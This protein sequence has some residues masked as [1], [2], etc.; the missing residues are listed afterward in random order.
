MA[1]LAIYPFLRGREEG[2]IRRWTLQ[3]PL[4]LI[5]LLSWDNWILIWVIL[6][7]I[8]AFWT[9]LSK[10][11]LSELFYP[12]WRGFYPI[13]GV[14]I[15]F[16]EN[17]QKYKLFV[18]SRRFYRAIKHKNQM[19]IKKDGIFGYL[20][21]FTGSWGGYYKEVNPTTTP[22]INWIALLGQLDIDLSNS[23]CHWS[24]LD[25][26]KQVLVVRAILPLL[27]RFLPHM[28]GKYL[29]HRKLSEEKV[30]CLFKT[31]L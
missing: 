16:T 15:C 31:I 4:Q 12:F 19:N 27:E 28:R 5:E 2:I 18:F 29:F 24:I 7:V 17:C 25:L 13:R 26:F 21:F 8:E 30:V 22:S 9:S 23:M 20:P 6:C 14:N 11:L 10:F 1:F 3:L